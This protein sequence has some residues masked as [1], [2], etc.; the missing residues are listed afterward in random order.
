MRIVG[1]FLFLSQ[2]AV[3][4]LVGQVVPNWVNPLQ[5]EMTFPA[6][7]YAVGFVSQSYSK[8]ENPDSFMEKMKGAARAALSESIFVSIK[9]ESTSQLSN[10]NGNSED[11]YQ[12]NTV[13]SSSLE[14]IGMKVESFVDAKKRVVYGF[15]YVKRRS[16]ISHYYGRL[17]SEM[18]RI[19]TAF[20]RNSNIDDKTE[21]Y[22]RHT[23]ELDALNTAKEYQTM[24]KYLNVSNELVLMTNRWKQM[25]DATLDAIDLLRNNDDI[26]IREAS[27]FLVDKLKDELGDEVGTIQMGLITYKSTGIPT[28]FSDYFGHLFRQALEEKRGGI[29]RSIKENGYVVSGTYW[30]GESQFQIIA[31]VNYVVDDEVVNRKAGGSIAVDIEKV[32]RLGVEYELRAKEEVIDKN[33]KLRPTSPVGGLVANLT[34]QK[35]SQSVIMKEGELLSLYVSVSRPSYIR[36]VNIWSDNQKF[37]LADNYYVNPDQT[38]QSI[39]LPL[40]WET[41]CP[42]GVEYLQMVAQDKPFA[43][44]ETEEKDGFQSIK[45]TLS[46]LLIK[47]RSVKKE[48]DY[49]AESTLVLTTME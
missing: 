23:G 13:T 8:D 2:I 14:A 12:K 15:A 1:I 35:G 16:L 18:S 17:S 9:S 48:S 4:T 28:E 42:C 21:A 7:E 44:I 47:T 41:S 34:T 49:F 37:L 33:E 30:P 26:G 31:N 45:G 3:G 19:E 5:R 39:R 6:K 27:Y 25:Y 38:N 40:S 24:L 43:P 11:R 46:S 29:S 20:E 22:K 32:D 10:Q 36:I